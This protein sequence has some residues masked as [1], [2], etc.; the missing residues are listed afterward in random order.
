MNN[1]KPSIEFE[2]PVLFLQ[3]DW[4]VIRDPCRGT[5]VPAVGLLLFDDI[6]N[7]KNKEQNEHK[8]EQQQFSHR[9]DLPSSRAVNT[10]TDA[11]LHRFACC[12]EGDGFP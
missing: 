10:G 12:L 6:S 11:L 4:G 5:I 3:K 2:A 7:E 1:H 9:E 8:I